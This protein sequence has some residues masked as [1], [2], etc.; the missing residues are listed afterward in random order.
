MKTIKIG[1]INFYKN[2]LWGDTGYNKV[3]RMI[4]TLNTFSENK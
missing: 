1:Q 4:D 2:D 3:T